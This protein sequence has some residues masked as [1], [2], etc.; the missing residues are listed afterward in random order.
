MDADDEL[1]SAE[2]LQARAAL[3]I[4]IAR[5]L[6]MA[7]FRTAPST[8]G[9]PVPPFTQADIDEVQLKGGV[10]IDYGREV[11]SG[12]SVWVEWQVAGPLNDLAIA[13]VAA[14][15]TV[16]TPTVHFSSVTDFTMADALATILTTAGYTVTKDHHE[17]D[18][19]PG[20]LLVRGQPDP[21]TWRNR[22]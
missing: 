16:P 22:T 10:E 3:A 13:D 1:A 2:L 19:S 17:V 11:E 15:P 4:E 12:T 14:G 18:Y 9:R 8:F 20:V 6:T 21:E 5:D 7:G